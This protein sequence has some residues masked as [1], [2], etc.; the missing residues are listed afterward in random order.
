MGT[1]KDLGCQAQN[2]PT[3]VLAD[4][5]QQEM[6]T[7]SAMLLFLLDISATFDIVYH[8]ILLGHLFGMGLCDT[9]LLSGSVPAWEAEPKS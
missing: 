1:D 6:D 8:G 9:A 4:E 2:F 3:A 7:E 5:L